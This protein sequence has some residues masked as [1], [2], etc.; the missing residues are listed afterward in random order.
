VRAIY[1][2]THDVEF[3]KEVVPKLIKYVRTSLIDV[4]F[5]TGGKEQET[6][7]TMVLSLLFILG[8]VASISVLHMTLHWVYQKVKVLFI[9]TNPKTPELDLHGNKHTAHLSNLSSNTT[10]SMVVLV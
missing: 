6:S 1:E 7:M 8:K 2:Q 9:L 4:G 3:L 5:S 10:S